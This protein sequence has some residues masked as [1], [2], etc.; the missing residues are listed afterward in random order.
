MDIVTMI[1]IVIETIIWG[2]FVLGYFAIKN[3]KDVSNKK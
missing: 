3:D 1:F 2:V